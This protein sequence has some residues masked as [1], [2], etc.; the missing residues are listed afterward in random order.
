MYFKLEFEEKGNFLI[1]KGHGELDVYHSLNFKEEAREKIN[2]LKEKIIIFDTTDVP[3][4][5]SSGLGSIIAL[6][7]DIHKN[8]KE[9]VITGMRKEVENLFKMTRTDRIVSIYPTIEDA[10]KQLS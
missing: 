5:D 2:E 9:L 3:Y 1:I 10:I 4:I 8:H 7:K 6:F